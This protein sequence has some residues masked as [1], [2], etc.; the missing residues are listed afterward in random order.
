MPKYKVRI[1]RS[2]EKQLARLPA[3]DQR[4]V[5]M[6]MVALGAEPRPHGVRKLAGVEAAYRIRVGQY[7]IIYEIDD[8]AVLVLVLKIGNR[9][10]VYK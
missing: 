10:E 4:R 7:R 5:A 3:E 2:A 6:A 8:G 1:T 9:K